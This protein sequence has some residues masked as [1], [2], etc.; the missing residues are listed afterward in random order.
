MGGRADPRRGHGAGVD[1]D[2]VAAIAAAAG[3][4]VGLSLADYVHGEALAAVPE[5]LRAFLRAVS[6]LPVWTPALCNDIT[7]RRDSEQHAARGRVARAVRHAST[8][9]SRRCTAATS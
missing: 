3:P 5:E 8:P 2:D 9:T 7:G 1:G 4:N 6:L